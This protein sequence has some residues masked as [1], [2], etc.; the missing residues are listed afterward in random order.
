MCRAVTVASVEP[1]I[2]RSI[3]LAADPAAVWALV[4]DLPGM[5][6]LSPENTGG[7]WV[8]AATGPAV[9]ARFR[10]VNR[11]GRRRWTTRVTVVECVA[12]QRFTFD[13][14]TPFGARVARWSYLITPHGNGC[15]LTEEWYWASNWVMR[16]FVGPRTTGRADRAG[17]A[18]H[19]IEHTLRA[20]KA[21]VE[22]AL[23]K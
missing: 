20:V 14:R 5:G 7:R 22:R 16:R 2:T 13:V 8:G 15:L 10:G 21:R 4:T 3:E 9:G 18:A 6:E 11:N 1:T 17:Y 12:P 19:A 23:R